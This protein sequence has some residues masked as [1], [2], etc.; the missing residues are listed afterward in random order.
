MANAVMTTMMTEPERLA[1]EAYLN[2][3]NAEFKAESD[4]AWSMRVDGNMVGWMRQIGKCR[5]IYREIM[6]VDFALKHQTLPF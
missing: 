6:E 3:L 5:V 4:K 1:T 2:D